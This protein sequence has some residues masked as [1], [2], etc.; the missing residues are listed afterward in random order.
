MLKT[1]T[2]FYGLVG[3][4]IYIFLFILA[5]K[6]LSDPISISL[7]IFGAI[8]WYAIPIC[9]K[10]LYA[11]RRRILD[12][13]YIYLGIFLA[14]LNLIFVFSVESSNT[15]GWMIVG[16]INFPFE[17]LFFVLNSIGIYQGSSGFLAFGILGS[18]TWFTIGTCIASRR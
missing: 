16:L 3:I 9:I 12:G 15:F 17:Y 11:E 4:F 1:K 10:K 6:K 8:I 5:N 2:K 18:L 14:G 7:L 13:N